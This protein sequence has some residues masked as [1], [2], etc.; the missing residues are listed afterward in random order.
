MIASIIIAT[1]NEEKYIEKCIN[2]LESQ[3][4]SKEQ[5]EIIV[6][7][8]GS[9]DNTQKLLERLKENEDN[10]VLLSNPKKIQSVAFNMGINQSRADFIFIIG[11]HAE[12]PSD[13]IEKS[14]ESIKSEDVD[15]VGGRIIMTGKNEVGRTYGAVRNTPFGGGISPYR[16]ANTK[17]YVDTVAF[18]CYKKSALIAV[19]GYNEELVKNQDNDINK[20]IIKAGGK[21]LFDPDIKFYYFTRDNYKGIIKQLYNYGYWEAKLLKKDKSQF[22][23]T[24]IIPSLFSIYTIL[25]LILLVIGIQWAL[26]IEMIPYLL[27][28]ALI[29]FKYLFEKRINIFRALIQ[30]IIIHFS[31]GI[32]FIYGF[33]K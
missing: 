8:G 17:K 19:G 2:S 18:G 26:I 15:C 33:L 30:F 23:I 12:Y 29:Y 4:F 32:G 16:Y 28:F 25:S 9:T 6:V 1:Y 10:I 27:V 21:I 31:I 20:R 7:D 3:S 22:G 13:F 5:Y 24:T 14:I 11:A